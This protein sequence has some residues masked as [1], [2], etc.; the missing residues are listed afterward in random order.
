MAKEE[1][2]ADTHLVVESI[3]I[4]KSASGGAFEQYRSEER[5]VGKEC[6]AE[7]RS[8]WSPEH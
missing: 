4:L 8:R 3:R 2:K 1:N 7:G 5:R 6:K